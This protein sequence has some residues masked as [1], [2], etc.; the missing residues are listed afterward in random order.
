MASATAL[1]CRAEGLFTES[2]ETDTASTEQTLEAYPYLSLSRP[3][4]GI[5]VKDGVLTTLSGSS[6][7]ISVAKLKPGPAVIELD[8]G[9]SDDSRGS[10]VVV[11]VMQ[12]R[13]V[14][15]P[16]W[17]NGGAFR[18]DRVFSNTHMGF[19]PGIGVMHHMTIRTDGAGHFDVEFIDGENPK[20]VYKV[21]FDYPDAKGNE[22]RLQ[23][24]NR[25][26]MFDNIRIE[27]VLP[28]EPKKEADDRSA[29]TPARTPAIDDNWLE[30]STPE[31]PENGYDPIQDPQGPT[32]PAHTEHAADPPHTAD[33]E[34]D[35]LAGLVSTVL[36]IAGIALAVIV[37]VLAV[38]F[39]MIVMLDRRDAKRVNGRGGP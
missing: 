18:V 11:E 17:S 32:P 23:S 13:L 29:D 33:D 1:P 6:M 15:H 30:R 21:S 12:T 25:A 22:V 3:T 4:Q 37:A 27:E 19:V 36:K 14:F 24:G 5:V 2:F 38:V 28:F 34:E 16:G 26:M 31:V 39:L 9:A 7:M 8:I 20:N 10:S 35:L